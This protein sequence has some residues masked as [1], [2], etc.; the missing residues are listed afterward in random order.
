MGIP[1]ITNYDGG[2]LLKNKH[3]LMFNRLHGRSWTAAGGPVE[4]LICT[5]HVHA[6]QGCRSCHLS[7]QALPSP[8]NSTRLPLDSLRAMGPS[9]NCHLDEFAYLSQ[10]F[11]RVS[12][13]VTA[14]TALETTMVSL[15]AS[16]WWMTRKCIDT[17]RVMISVYRHD[18]CST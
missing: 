14:H 10:H 13:S 18:L 9:T 15:S 16:W 17:K 2:H 8:A 11:L 6:D 4:P 12:V 1:R 5:Q 3:N 7:R